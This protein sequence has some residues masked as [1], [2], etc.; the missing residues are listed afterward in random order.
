MA[1]DQRR[2]TGEARAG[3]GGSPI[4]FVPPNL[5]AQI[6][7]D[8]APARATTFGLIFH[9]FSHGISAMLQRNIISLKK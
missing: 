7:P 2:R 3:A 9:G 8:H 5:S 1:E 6:P 4:D